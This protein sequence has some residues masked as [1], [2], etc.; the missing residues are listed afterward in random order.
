MTYEPR[1]VLTIENATRE[2]RREF[3]ARAVL[4]ENDL[5]TDALSVLDIYESDNIDV[6]R[7]MV[8]DRH[9]V[10]HY[11]VY[12]LGKTSYWKGGWS[13]A[14]RVAKDKAYAE[15]QEDG[16]DV[17]KNMSL[18][19]LVE[20]RWAAV[21]ARE[22]REEREVQAALEAELER[23]LR[24]Q[25][26]DVRKDF[27]AWSQMARAARND[28]REDFQLGVTMRWAY[29]AVDAWPKMLEEHT[30]KL[31]QNPVH[32]LDWSGDFMQAAADFELAKHVVELFEDGLSF[33][34][35]RE[36]FEREMFNQG[37][38]AFSRST[39]QMSNL[40]EDAKRVALMSVVS[41]LVGRS[42]W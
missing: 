19:H 8:R 22:E 32:T 2:D 10:T 3:I 20:S 35:M 12:G 28:D 30:K 14:L 13:D 6:L 34:E 16:A 31:A 40:M 26:A 7:D 15:A 4:F 18:R 33:D 1:L 17:R 37:S 38:R 11:A 21:T 9:N 39:S 24:K 27:N 36:A 29:G 25:R 23:E 42:H 41:R 5:E